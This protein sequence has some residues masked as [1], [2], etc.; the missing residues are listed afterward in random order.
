MPR[1][2]MSSHPL[3]SEALRPFPGIMHDRQEFDTLALQSIGDD[4]MRMANH[5]FTRPFNPPGAA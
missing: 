4:V 5:E 3:P 2:V 1:F